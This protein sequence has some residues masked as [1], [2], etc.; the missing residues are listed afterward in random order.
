M[1]SGTAVHVD[2]ESL[3]HLNINSLAAASEF[4]FSKVL[5]LQKH[6]QIYNC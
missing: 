2:T 4:H 6:L 1:N 3:I 5:S